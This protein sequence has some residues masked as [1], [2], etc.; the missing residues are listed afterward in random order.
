MLENKVLECEGSS[1][2]RNVKGQATGPTSSHSLA[3]SPILPAKRWCTFEAG[4]NTFLQYVFW[5]EGS[6]WDQQWR[7]GLRWTLCNVEGFPSI[8]GLQ[9]AWFTKLLSE[10]C[11]SAFTCIWPL[12]INV[13]FSFLI[14]ALTAIYPASSWFPT[15]LSWSITTINSAI[16]FLLLSH[17]HRHL[18]LV[19]FRRNECID[20]GHHP[21]KN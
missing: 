17:H 16:R 1:F 7:N 9:T 2:L 19:M 20:T 11:L 10:F 6:Y 3:L 4:L 14:K 12:Q 21:R 13:V 5:L 8:E 18:S 15:S